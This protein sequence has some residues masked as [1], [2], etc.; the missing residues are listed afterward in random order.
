MRNTEDVARCLRQSDILDI[1]QRRASWRSKSSLLQ[2][3]VDKRNIGRNNVSN[4]HRLSRSSMLVTCSS[5]QHCWRQIISSLPWSSHLTL[6]NWWWASRKEVII[7]EGVFSCHCYSV[8]GAFSVPG[9]L[10]LWAGDH[11]KRCETCLP[12]ISRPVGW[13]TRHTYRMYVELSI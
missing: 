3:H 5:Q 12:I 11:E 9:N 6:S 13:S 10:L 4:A 2:S 8:N 7:S 1:E